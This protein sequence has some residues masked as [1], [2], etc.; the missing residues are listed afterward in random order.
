MHKPITNKAFRIIIRIAS[1]VAL[2]F[3]LNSSCKKPSEIQTEGL[4]CAGGEKTNHIT[5]EYLAKGSVWAV[6][7]ELIK[8]SGQGK[9]FVSYQEAG[10]IIYFPSGTLP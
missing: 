8:D 7:K 6:R 10:S 5:Q 4:P 1:G 3:A 9:N 2:F